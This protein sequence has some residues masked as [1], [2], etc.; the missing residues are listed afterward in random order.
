LSIHLPAGKAV[1]QPVSY[2]EQVAKMVRE[3]ILSGD[4]PPGERLSEVALSSHLGIS[5][6]PIREGLRKLSDEG[7]VVVHPRRGAFVASY[8]PDEIRQLME[9]RQALDVAAAGL[10]AKRANPEELDALQT[11]LEAAD[12]AYQGA[13]SASPPWEADFHILILRAAGNKKIF[14]R[15]ME[16]HTQLHLARF[17]SGAQT[18]S[19]RGVRNEHQA[20]LD[21]LRS[22]DSTKAESAMRAHLQHAGKRIAEVVG[23]ESEQERD[24]TVVPGAN[25]QFIARP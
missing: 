1:E 21:A 15:G 14:A 10:A 6:S 18:G 24:A 19:A 13:V 20:I 25:S 12:V 8:D 11:A 9:F 23:R 17:R 4:Y 5:R 7:L 2:A 22:G 3:A 16:V